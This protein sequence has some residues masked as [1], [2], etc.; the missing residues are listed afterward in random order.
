MNPGG[1]K[2][3]TSTDYSVTESINENVD[4][5]LE[6]VDE[7]G[8]FGKRKRGALKELVRIH[9]LWSHDIS[10]AVVLSSPSNV[11]DHTAC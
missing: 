8:D 2:S 9:S 5:L 6:I 10:F 1:R 4:L 3:G 7:E 11:T